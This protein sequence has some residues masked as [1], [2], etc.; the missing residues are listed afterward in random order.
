MSAPLLARYIV[1][2][3]VMQKTILRNSKCAPKLLMNRTRRARLA[4]SAAFESGG[5]NKEAILK[6]AEELKW[7]TGTPHEIK[8]FLLCAKILEN[9]SKV[10]LPFVENAARIQRPQTGWKGIGI[11]GVEVA[12][13]PL[14]VFSFLERKVTKV[15]AILVHNSQDTPLDKELHGNKAGDYISA[16]L[17]KMIEE[18]MSHIGVPSASHCFAIDSNLRTAYSS[19]KKVKT[20]FNHMAATCENIA[21]LWDGVPIK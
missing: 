2:D 17:F 18:R 11:E 1:S 9:M 13:E 8:D 12:F 5:F 3:P 15:G 16:L 14:V 7:E 6:R 21:S 10:D 20:L 19:P 4:L